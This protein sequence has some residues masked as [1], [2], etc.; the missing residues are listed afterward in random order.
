MGALV[1]VAEAFLGAYLAFMAFVLSG[2]MIDDGVAFRLAES[3][4]VGIATQRVAFWVVAG[5]ASWASIVGANRLLMPFFRL[6]ARRASFWLG[7]CVA[8]AII[9][10]SVA[11]A[12]S[13]LREKPFL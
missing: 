4:W 2:W 7:F 12:I 1:L 9:A 6:Q 3:G 5:L 8:I 13:F 10:T 11:G